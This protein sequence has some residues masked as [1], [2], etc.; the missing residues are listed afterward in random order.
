MKF[1]IQRVT[2]AK[3]E[4]DQKTVGAIDRGYMILVGIN[5]TDT[6]EIMDKM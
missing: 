2:E 1:V 5:A 3:V 4:V 6:K